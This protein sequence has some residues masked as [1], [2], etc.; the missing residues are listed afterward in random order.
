MAECLMAHCSGQWGECDAH[1]CAV[2]DEATRHGQ[3]IL[4]AWR[5]DPGQ[6]FEGDNRLWLITEADRSVTT[7]L[8][9]EEY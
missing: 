4:S 7:A 3:R 2:N 5:I 6:P 1:D 9:P 8:L